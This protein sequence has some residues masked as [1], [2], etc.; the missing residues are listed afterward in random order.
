MF[1]VLKD[2]IKSFIGGVEDK[3]EKE[4]RIT[5]STKAKSLLTGKIRLSPG[6]I[7][8]TLWQ[9]NLDLI[10]SD[11]AVETAEHITNTIRDRLLNSEIDRDRI[12]DH[13]TETIRGTLSSI[14][15]S[16]GHLDVVGVIRSSER[17]FK[18]MFLGVNGTG[19]T[20]TIA[21]VAKHL[22][23]NNLKV[24]LA[25]GDTFRAGAI[26]QLQ[27]H[28][29]RLGVKLIT[30]Q[31]GS[32]SAAVIYDA[33]EHAKAKGI[34]V[35][36]AD[37][38]GRMQTNT[39][40]MDELEKIIRVNKPDLRVFV[41]D[42]LTGNDAVE[43]AREFNNSVGFDAVILTKLDADSK[44]G[45]AISIA[46]ETRKPIILVGM[47]QGYDDLDEFNSEWFIDKILK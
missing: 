42:S 17:P 45:S 28:A 24:V 11:V 10:Q 33:V 5:A 34:D 36:L 25:A 35:V 41:G 46:H 22:M 32:D 15:D 2:R 39:N 47:G 31:K 7:E 20:T 8:D 14:F 38:A 4:Y 12:H 16:C 18:I 6:D 27:T 30:H 37:T 1:G 40:L 3:A 9:L 43:Q 44:G 23:N 19:K 21:K 29:Q 26:E 13:I